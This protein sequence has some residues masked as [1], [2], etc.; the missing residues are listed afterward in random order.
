MATSI[1]TSHHQHHEWMGNSVAIRLLNVCRN[2]FRQWKLAF[3]LVNVVYK[4]NKTCFKSL[5]CPEI[6]ITIWK[7]V[8]IR[9]LFVLF[10]IWWCSFVNPSIQSYKFFGYFSKLYFVWITACNLFWDPSHF[11]AMLC[12]SFMLLDILSPAD[13]RSI[14]IHIVYFSCENILGRPNMKFSSQLIKT[15][16]KD[17]QTVCNNE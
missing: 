16:D 1:S 6:V 14:F 7:C 4:N 3:Q 13:Y 10:L 2:R 8:F 9:P 17:I 5:F 15:L 11:N 12:V